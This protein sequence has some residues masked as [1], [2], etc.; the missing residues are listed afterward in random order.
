MAITLNSHSN[1]VRQ[2][3]PFWSTYWSFVIFLM[4]V[5]AAMLGIMLDL[6]DEPKSVV[7]S[8]ITFT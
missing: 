4:T 8:W 7:E 1:P 3:M 2:N 5:G 6:K